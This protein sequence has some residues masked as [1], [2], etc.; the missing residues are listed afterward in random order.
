MHPASQD[1]RSPSACLERAGPSRE[2]T[3]SRRVRVTSILTL[4]GSRAPPVNLVTGTNWPGTTDELRVKLQRMAA[5]AGLLAPH[6]PAEYG[7]GGGLIS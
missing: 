7:G 3:P 4:R 1:E 6:A 2:T 5:A